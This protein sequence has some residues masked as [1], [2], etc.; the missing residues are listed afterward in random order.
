MQ[1]QISASSAAVTTNEGNMERGRADQPRH[2]Y[3]LPPHVFVCQT[4]DCVV[5]LDA[6]RDRYVGVGGADADALRTM[7]A[8]RSS[9]QD[10]AAGAVSEVLPQVAKTLDC[11]VANGL[12]T[13]EPTISRE[14]RQVDLQPGS[15]AVGPGGEYEHA[16]RFTHI[17]VALMACIDAWLDLRFRGVGGTVAR[18]IA[19]KQKNGR[20][21]SN[22]SSDELRRL[23]GIFRVIRPFLYA[24]KDKCLF[25][26]L[27]LYKFLRHYGLSPTWVIGVNISPFGAHC[28]L[29]YGECVLDDSPKQT[30][31]FTP[32]AAI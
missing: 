5:F 1:S 24:K 3:R 30:L 17:V 26:G 23:V 15:M 12:L 14:F 7:L 16:P 28:W 8:A 32:L 21:S 29:Q 2:A 13:L 10:A 27:A 4:Q 22:A 9:P 19:E 25:H 31:E 11:L 18:L 6:R 20:P